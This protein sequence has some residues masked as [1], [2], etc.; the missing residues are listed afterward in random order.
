MFLELEEKPLFSL[1]TTPLVQQSF[2]WSQ[3]KQHQGYEALAFDLKVRQ[4][5]FE[6]QPSSAYLLDDILLL[7]LPVGRD[8]RIAY[9]PYG[10]L[11]KPRQED[12]GPFLEE[13]SE[14]LRGK[15]GKQTILVRYDLPWQKPWDIEIDS[16]ELMELRLNWSTKEK[17]LRKAMSDQLP[18]DTMVVSLLDNEDIILERMHPKTRYNIR[19]ALRHGIEVRQGGLDD[20]PL[21]YE[22]YRQTAKRNGITLHDIRFFRSFFDASDQNAGFRLLFSFLGGTPLSAMF[23]TFSDKRASYLFGASSNQ[24]RESMS[25]YALQWEAMRQAKTLGCTSYDLFGVAPEAS[26]DHPL[27]GLYRFKKGF[28][29]AMVHRLGC[30]DYLYEQDL[31]E[32]LGSYEMVDKGYHQR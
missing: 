15:L 22:L 23:L 17:H 8:V 10:P 14:Q 28:G 1:N 21:F 26:P 7:S 13:L 6:G 19:L 32:S 3:V 25:T 20:L 24:N 27:A 30:W 16:S 12:M 29:G 4:E 31:S 5:E 11:I 9:A 2:F 18:C